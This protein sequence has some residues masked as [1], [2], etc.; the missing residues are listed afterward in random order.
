MKTKDE[1]IKMINEVLSGIKIIK[2]YGWEEAFLDKVTVERDKEVKDNQA[3]LFVQLVSY[4]FF[5]ISPTIVLASTI[6]VYVFADVGSEF[7]AEKVFVSIALFNILQ[8]PLELLPII[9]TYL[10]MCKV[11]LDRVSSF[12]AE[13]ELDDYTERK[14]DGKMAIKI[15]NK[16]RFVWSTESTRVKVDKKIKNGINEIKCKMNKDEDEIKLETKINNQPDKETKQFE[17]KDIELQVPKCSFVAVI[18]SVGS[19]KSS[20]I[21][22]ILGEMHLVENDE[23]VKGE[24]NISEEQTFCYVAQ[25]AWI[26]NDSFKNNILFGKEFNEEIY[27]DVIDACALEQDL[28]QL[29]GDEIEIGEKGINLSGGQ[30]QRV[31]LARACYSSLSVGDNKQII[32]LDDPLSAV[33]AH[34][35]KHLCEN[36]LSS[37]TG[38]LKDTTRIL[39]TNQLN[40]LG[41]LNVDQII[42]LKDGKIDLKCTFDQLMEMERNG[43][44]DEYE[45]KLTQNGSKD[46]SEDEDKKSKKSDSLV[47]DEN[48]KIKKKDDEKDLKK[49]LIEKEKHE[50][51]RVSLKNYQ[52]YL[53]N[54]GYF[55]AILTVLFLIAD[56]VFSVWSRDYLASWTNTTIPTNDTK[57][58]KEFNRVHILNYTYISLFQCLFSF[59]GNFIVV[60]GIVSTIKLFHKKLLYKILR[61]P[62]NFFDTTPLGK[63]KLLS[64]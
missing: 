59:L 62:M 45:L 44:L 61:S 39:V 48:S 38:I 7:S 18:G 11:S 12:L 31:S 14:F 47:S 22:A 3:N 40:Q 1:R 51:G 13:D 26:Q 28:E 9:F 32:L 17:L 16:A 35:S 54:F 49:K 23:G 36:V 64:L 42:L 10:T 6:A 5:S 46:E 37:K 41:D 43:K 29:G 24:V 27:K 34:V 30:K 52:I 60:F 53:Q 63:Q 8:L 21:S 25:Q 56:N 57:Y 19:G 50:I 58:I 55:Y 15:K 20:L 33:D 2:L 4:V